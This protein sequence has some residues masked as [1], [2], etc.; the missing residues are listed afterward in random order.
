[1]NRALK[2][3]AVLAWMGF[4]SLF[5]LSGKATACATLHE[6]DL[7]YF[8]NAQIVVRARIISYKPVFD[9]ELQERR[10][11]FREATSKSGYRQLADKLSDRS[12]DSIRIK[13]EVV[14]TIFGSPRLDNW[15]ANWVHST[16]AMSEQWKGPE[17]VI[18]G[19][20]AAIDRHGMPF[21]QLVQQPCALAMIL[22]D[23][24]D[25]R[26]AVTDAISAQSRKHL[27]YA[28]Q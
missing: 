15:E 1:M 18:V 12:A 25:N 23:S 10:R 21:V 13:F 14:E 7:S 8:S 20:R 3:N 19:L 6:Q 27:G 4:L 24:P 5:S 28:F 26:K 2:L 22:E 16:F 9:S 11:K 17:N